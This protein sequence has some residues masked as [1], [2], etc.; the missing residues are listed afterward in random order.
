MIADEKGKFDFPMI[1][2]V[3]YQGFKMTVAPTLPITKDSIIYGSDGEIIHT[4]IEV[5]E[6]LQQI[7]KKLSLRPHMVF[8]SKPTI[9]SLCGDIEIHKLIFNKMD[10]F[11]VLD[12]NRVFP[13]SFDHSMK[14]ENTILFR[15]LRPEFI[16]MV[17]KDFPKGFSSDALSHWQACDPNDQEMSKDVET[18]TKLLED[19]VRKNAQ[20]L[21]DPKVNPIIISVSISESQ[22]SQSNMY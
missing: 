5:H 2:I 1:A 8:S 18:A 15:R 12:L 7:A 4:N 20:Y 10:I 6:E 11:S 17:S 3:E 22:M 21:S 13:P 16:E 9:T 19:H 14:T